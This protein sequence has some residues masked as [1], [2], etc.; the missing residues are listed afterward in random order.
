MKTRRRDESSVLYDSLHDS[1]A[2]FLNSCGAIT[3]MFLLNK[4]LFDWRN[5]HFY[6]A[7]INLKCQVCWLRM[8]FLTSGWNVCMVQMLILL[9]C[10][11][12]YFSIS[13]W[14]KILH[15][16]NMLI[17]NVKGRTPTKRPAMALVSICC[18]NDCMYQNNVAETK[19]VIIWYIYEMLCQRSGY[20]NT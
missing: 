19:T 13:T 14:T 2:S 16:Q 1:K 17:N 6:F 8:L 15:C 4:K 12:Y 20:I 7:Q 18:L 5:S 11:A 9:L 10:N 3:I